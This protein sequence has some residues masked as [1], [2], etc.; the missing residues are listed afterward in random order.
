MYIPGANPGNTLH[1]EA[2]VEVEV[3]GRATEPM[4]AVQQAEQIGLL[5]L[6]VDILIGQIGFKAKDGCR[7]TL[8]AD[9][10]MPD[11]TGW[12]AMRL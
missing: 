4:F 11:I 5:Q 12:R 10:P 1:T 9:Q 3:A 7:I 2:F 8:L 6:V